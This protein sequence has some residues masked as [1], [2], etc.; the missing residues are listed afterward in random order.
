L[1]GYSG[2]LST[3]TVGSHIR[4][5]AN[6]TVSVFRPYPFEDEYG[7]VTAESCDS[8]SSGSEDEYG[9]VTAES[10][11]SDSS[12]SEVD[13]DETVAPLYLNGSG[14]DTEVDDETMAPLDVSA[15]TTE[16]RPFD[17]ARH[18]DF[19]SAFF[20]PSNVRGRCLWPPG[21]DIHVSC[22]A[23]RGRSQTAT[24]VRG[25]PPP[26]PVDGSGSHVSADVHQH[27]G[28]DDSLGYGWA[29]YVL[30]PTYR[31]VPRPGFMCANC[32]P[33]PDR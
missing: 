12:G 5:G 9:E 11:D 32:R 20:C 15:G 23:H 6:S 27:C 2:P 18:E 31:P 26:Y 4:A 8:D 22:D 10:C 30:P 21:H 33:M 3:G 17:G 16:I 1:F 14:S 13:G 7:E 19:G 25:Y 29:P 24:T 28:Y